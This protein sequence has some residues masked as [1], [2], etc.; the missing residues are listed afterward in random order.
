MREFR[1]RSS[2]APAF[3]RLSAVVA[4]VP[5]VLSGCSVPFDERARAYV[6]MEPSSAQTFLDDFSEVA[7]ARGLDPEYG[8]ADRGD[9]RTLHVI[10]ATG[11]ALVVWVQNMPLSSRQCPE[12]AGIDAGQFSINVRPAMWFPFPG[13]RATSLSR[14]LTGDLRGKGYRVTSDPVVPCSS[15]VLEAERRE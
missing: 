13:E 10:E 6:V 15:A 3:T 11:Q 7:R 4:A 14:L 8:R 1:V 12:W 9:G 2:R 5:L